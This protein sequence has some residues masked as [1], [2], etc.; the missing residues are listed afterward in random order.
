MQEF[1]R[2]LLGE[3][4][5]TSD[6]SFQ[7]RSPPPY[8]FPPRWRPTGESEEWRCVGNNN[9]LAATEPFTRYASRFRVLFPDFPDSAASSHM[10]LLTNAS[11]DVGATCR[12]GLH[13]RKPRFDLRGPGRRGHAG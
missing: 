9:K 13:L 4:T 8:L 5:S 10:I 12:S 2:S 1:V 11:V 6:T 7:T 3:L